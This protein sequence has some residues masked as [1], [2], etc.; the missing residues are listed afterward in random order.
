MNEAVRSTEGSAFHAASS[1]TPRRR[2]LALVA[3]A[4]AFVMDLL[5]T[6]IINVAI[7]SI[8]QTMGADKAA[9]EWIIAGYATAFA[10]LLIV[11]GRL[12]DS[13]GYR[14]MFLIGIALFTATSMACGMAPTAFALQAARLLQG[15]SAALMVPQVMALVQVMYPPEQRYKVYTVFGFLGGFSAALGPIVGGLLI[16]ANWFGLGWR[17][18]FLIN[19]PIGLFSLAAGVLL[20]PAGRGVNA[21][22]VDLRGAAL[23]IVVLFAI[24]APLIEGPGRG[25]PPGLVLLLAA[26]A[27]LAWGTVRYLRW[28]QAAHGDALVSPA[29]FKLRKVSL[30]LLCTLCINPVLPG[31]L[32][33]MTFVLQTGIGLSASQ[34][35]YAC[36]PIALGAMGA[37]TLLG[38]WL[39]RRL[40]VRVMMIGVGVTSFSLCL[41][42]WSVHGGLLAHGALAVAQFG[43]GLGMGLCGPQLSNATLQ[44][45]PMSD[46]GVAAGLLTAVQQIAAALGVALAGMAFFHGLHATTASAS[47]YTNAYLQVLPL[48][49][50]L[51]AAALFGATRLAKAMEK[52]RQVLGDQ[53]SLECPIIHDQVR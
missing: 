45:V 2:T 30:G 41:A 6:T 10:V 39:F 22:A 3:V 5:D 47:D 46:A 1:F 34:M 9:L 8:G 20:L 25:W 53:S 7:P 16:D 48:F 50:G 44:D 29:L 49:L 43:M 21:V 42:A 33:V 37:I 4:L 17:L 32:L 31:Y 18:T 38:P 27:P 28:R 35:A 19:L 40:G 52:Q 11:G 13:Y 12:G 23:S 14:R 36:A 51:M 26:T 15:A 24:L